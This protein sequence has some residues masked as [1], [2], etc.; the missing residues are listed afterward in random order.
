MYLIAQYIKLT[1]L[2]T[3]AVTPLPFGPEF[4]EDLLQHPS[5]LEVW[6]TQLD[7]GETELVE[8]RL[9]CNNAML[10]VGHRETSKI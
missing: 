5:R 1:D 10:A 7:E 3:Y 6:E 9:F 4:S 2:A 8:Y